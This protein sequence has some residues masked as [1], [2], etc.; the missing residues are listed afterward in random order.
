MYLQRDAVGFDG[1]VGAGRVFVQL[2]EEQRREVPDGVIA[3]IR[4]LRADALELRAR[5]PPKSSEA[6]AGLSIAA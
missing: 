2:S 1:G 6:L 4:R 3:R 5:S